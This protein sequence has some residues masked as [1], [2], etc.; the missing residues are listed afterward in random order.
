LRQDTR[1]TIAPLTDRREIWKRLLATLIKP[2]VTAEWWQK[3]LDVLQA[4]VDEIPCYT[5]RFERSG[6]IVAELV[7]LT[8]C[9]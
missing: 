1:N 9:S 5:M 7:R 4:I 8:D 6:A 3:E 2:L